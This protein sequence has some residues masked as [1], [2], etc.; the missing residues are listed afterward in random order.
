MK[1][2]GKSK[3]KRMNDV[4]LAVWV[5][6]TDD[7]NAIRSA[8]VKGLKNFVARGGNGISKNLTSSWSKENWCGNINIGK[9]RF[10]FTGLAT[11]NCAE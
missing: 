11:K 1:T 9:L 4:D 8:L 6:G 5:S 10:K 2:K 7:L 3:P